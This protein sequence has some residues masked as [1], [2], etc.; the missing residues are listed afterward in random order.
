MRRAIIPVAMVAAA[1]AAHLYVS[2]ASPPGQPQP[3]PGVPQV[4]PRAPEAS[5]VADETA[6]ADGE[7]DDGT[8]VVLGLRVRK[9][10]NCTVELRDYVTPAG[11]MFSAYSCTPGNPRPEHPYAVYDDATLEAME[12]LGA[13]RARILIRDRLTPFLHRHSA[14]LDY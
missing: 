13:A 10:R 4:Q 11:E 7:R 1:A 5:W 8:E 14:R 9:D 12:R 3:K 2:P 6:A